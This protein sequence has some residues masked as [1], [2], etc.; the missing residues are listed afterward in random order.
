MERYYCKLTIWQTSLLLKIPTILTL[1]GPCALN[2]V[3]CH[4]SLVVQMEPKSSWLWRTESSSMMQTQVKWLTLWEATKI[5]FIVLLIRKM[6]RNLRQEG[7]WVK[8]NPRLYRA[9]NSVVIWSTQG[10]GLLKYSH[11]SAI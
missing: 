4:N 11:S 5:Q 1:F 8:V 7:K 10:E 9:D 3:S 2:L 6:D